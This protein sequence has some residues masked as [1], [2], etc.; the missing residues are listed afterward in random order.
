MAGSAA[1]HPEEL[2]EGGGA[3]DGGQAGGSAAL[4][5][6]QHL[7]QGRQ[8]GEGLA[9]AAATIWRFPLAPR[10]RA[11][12][13]GA[14][15]R[16]VLDQGQ[17]PGEELASVF[18]AGAALPLRRRR[19]RR[20]P[21]L[22]AA[23][24][25]LGAVLRLHRHHE[26]LAQQVAHG[27]QP[28]HRQAELADGLVQGLHPVQDAVMAARG[29]CMGAR[30]RPPDA[31]PAGV[32][33]LAAGDG[34][35][36]RIGGRGRRWRC[37]AR[38]RRSRRCRCGGHGACLLPGHAAGQGGELLLEP[39]MGALQPDQSILDGPGPGNGH[40]PPRLP[41][42]PKCSPF[43]G[44]GA[45]RVRSLW[46]WGRRIAA[47]G[48]LILL[49]RPGADLAAAA[50]AVEQTGAR[51]LWRLPLIQGLIVTCPGPACRAALVGLEA[52]AAVEDDIRSSRKGG[53]AAAVRAPADPGAVV[54][55]GVER[56][57][58]L[59]AWARSRGR[60]VAVAVIDTGADWEHPGLA[61]RVRGGI[62]ILD[63]EAPPWDDNGHGTHVAGIV[64]GAEGP[65]NIVGVA[66]EADLYVVKAF[67]RRG[68]ANTADVLLALQWC[69]DYRMQVVN[70]TFSKDKLSAKRVRGWSN[71][72]PA[73][74]QLPAFFSCTSCVRS[75]P[76]IYP[77]AMMSL[78]LVRNPSDRTYV[79]MICTGTSAFVSVSLCTGFDFLRMWITPSCTL[80]RWRNWTAHALAVSRP[81][82]TLEKS[83]GAAHPVHRPYGSPVCQLFNG[84]RM[85]WYSVFPSPSPA[86]FPAGRIRTGQC[87]RSSVL[88]Y[89]PPEAG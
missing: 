12:A 2:V 13:G 4:I 81:P 86:P 21:G 66:P 46:Q 38:H 16:Q 47:P 64:A 27:L 85:Y 30:R 68:S 87:W 5:P 39:V 29:R 83:H 69:A 48:R 10:R 49:L 50:A 3:K 76:R 11:A 53:L 80:C 23:G 18:T 74:P 22:G 58:A 88:F 8:G 73:P 77:F 6:E 20:Q 59:R 51:V 56:I 60:G 24:G 41:S 71:Q 54:P 31:Q 75:N 9:T 45:T 33:G 57:G 55:W 19:L 52:V 79:T 15:A 34:N 35:G 61:D 67:D 65:G 78:A 28:L 14:L 84:S 36:G 43:Y 1:G 40:A 70:T 63:V 62:N 37:G 42:A 72:L 25:G 32:Q 7:E 89:R 26:A 17:Q 82:G 44:K